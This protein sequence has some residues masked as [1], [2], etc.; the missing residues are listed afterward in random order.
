MK[1]LELIAVM[2]CLLFA[3]AISSYHI[4]FDGYLGIGERTWGLIWAIG[5]NGFAL[6]LCGLV[7]V[8][9][10]GWISRLMKFVFIP[11]FAFKLIYHISCYS[12]VYLFS[13]HTW[14]TIWSYVLVLLFIV[15]ISYCLILIRK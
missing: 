10:V 4:S 6:S 13:P 7:L 5:E 14:E 8:Y 1:R 15:S 11:Y 12:G 9:S 3:I 2:G